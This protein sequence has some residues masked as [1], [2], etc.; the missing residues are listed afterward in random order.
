LHISSIQIENYKGFIQ[1]EEIHF[2][3]GF[4]VIVGANNAGKTA[5]IEALSLKFQNKLHRNRVGKNSRVTIGIKVDA[6]EFIDIILKQISADRDFF[7]VFFP[8]STSGGSS[9]DDQIELLRRS[10]SD[11][12]SNFELKYIYIDEKFTSAEIIGYG[13]YNNGRQPIA[14]VEI[15]FQGKKI[16]QWSGVKSADSAFVVPLQFGDYFKSKI[17]SLSAERMKVAEAPSGMKSELKPDASNLAEV[18]HTLQSI[19]KKIKDFNRLVTQ[20]FPEIKSISAF[21]KASNEGGMSQIFV[22][23]E[24]A[25][26]SGNKDFAVSLS[27]SGTGIGQVL[28]ILYIVLTSSEPRTIIIDEPQS[29]LHP[30]AIRKLFGILREKEFAHHQYIITTHSPLVIAATNPETIVQVRK[31]ADESQ[32]ENFSSSNRHKLDEFLSEVGAKLSD[33][34]GAD[35]ILW[36]EGPTEEICFPVI[37]SKLSDYSLMGSAILGVK[38]TG[39]FAA[40]M[41]DKILA[42]HSKLS[43]TPGLLPQALG[44]LFDRELLSD[45]KVEEY[46]KQHMY[47]IPRR[48][49]ENYLL[50]PQAIA[51]LLSNLE[52]LPTLNV[53]SAKIV[54]WLE[55]KLRN[56]KYFK[57][58]PIPQNFSD[59]SWKKTVDGAALLKDIFSHFS[60]KTVEYDKKIYGLRLTQWLLDNSPEDL[61]ELADGI[62]KVIKKGKERLEGKSTNIQD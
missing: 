7:S 56:E 45:A 25:Y 16:S 35:N 13:K 37:L 21:S 51:D 4:N 30:G 48:M 18:I 44:F 31:I 15:T 57:S 38:N 62:V 50:K 12:L 8:L 10:F 11:P 52:E 49:Y 1:S 2:T 6:Q 32:I 61:K 3:P 33:V 58:N 60:E 43:E 5:L 55:N 54:E 19:T 22:W 39:D 17:Y 14:A 28:A 46:E 42:I 26:T 24:I 41:A 9:P 29:F 20:V 53:E 34:F 27:E 23:D 36:V 40:K 47:F 59:D